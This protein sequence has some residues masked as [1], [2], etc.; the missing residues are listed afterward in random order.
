MEVMPSKSEVELGIEGV[1]M[2]SVV[3]KGTRSARVPEQSHATSHAVSHE[4]RRH[5]R[6]RTSMYR[7][8][9]HHHTIFDMANT[10]Q[11]L[12]GQIY[13]DRSRS[14]RLKRG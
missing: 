4:P 13:N 1:E 2:D 7:G 12:Q 11:L 8:R 6:T 14:V 10:T 3:T 9:R 5:N